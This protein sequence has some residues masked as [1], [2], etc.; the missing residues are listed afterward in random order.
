[1]TYAAAESLI[2]NAITDIDYAA[3]SREIQKMVDTATGHDFEVFATLR[4]LAIE[5]ARY[6]GSKDA[7]LVAEV[8]AAESRIETLEDRL[9]SL[10]GR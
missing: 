7:G 6:F 2:N 9:D 3:A 4:D 10:L 8:A 5:M 1:M